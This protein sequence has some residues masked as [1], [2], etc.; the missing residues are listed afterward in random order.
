MRATR[1]K[2]P[3][4]TPEEVPAEPHT[5][6]TRAKVTNRGVVVPERASTAQHLPSASE[7]DVLRILWSR[8]PCS[9][10]EVQCEFPTKAYT[11]I[12]TFLQ[13]LREKRLARRFE[14]ARGHVYEANVA[15]GPI[16]A[17][18]AQRL[19]EQFFKQSATTLA[20]QTLEAVALS[21]RE[22]NAL[23]RLI[24]QKEKETSPTNA[25]S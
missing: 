21:P 19:S 25:A 24:R 15:E 9:A 4:L 8:G 5:T 10:R 12:L 1:S 7:L 11:T 22:L 23:R 2:P 17:A 6:H 16:L 3:A 20:L 13:K 14:H 18:L